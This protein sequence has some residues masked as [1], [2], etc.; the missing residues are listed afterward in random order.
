[1]KLLVHCKNIPLYIGHIMFEIF[2]GNFDVYEEILDGK[3]DRQ[4]IVSAQNLR[5]QYC[6]MLP[7][8]F[9]AIWKELKRLKL[10]YYIVFLSCIYC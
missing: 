8:W 9:L 5:G 10:P 3:T 7:D 6:Y 1:M 4:K 2:F